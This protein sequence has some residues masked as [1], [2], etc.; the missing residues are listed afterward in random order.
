MKKHC[1]C[2]TS[3]QRERPAPDGAASHGSKPSEVRAAMQIQQGDAEEVRW[4][5]EGCL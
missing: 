3:H 1:L 2:L 4:W 5:R